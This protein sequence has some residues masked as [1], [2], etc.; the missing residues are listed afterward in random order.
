VVGSRVVEQ[1]ADLIVGRE[2]SPGDS[3]GEHLRISEDHRMS[4]ERRSSGRHH[5]RMTGEIV[6]EINITTGVNHPD[7]DRVYVLWQGREIRF[8][9]NGRKRSSIDLGGL[10]EVV[11]AP[12]RSRHHRD[13]PSVS[14]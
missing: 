12:C 7:S 2:S 8:R 14:N 4:L 5:P 3:G 13:S 11:I 6:D 9:S 1:A 10:P